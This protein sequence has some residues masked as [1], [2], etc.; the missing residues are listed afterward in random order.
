M[1]FSGITDWRRDLKTVIR[2]AGGR[3]RDM[4]FLCTESQIKEEA[5]LQDIDALL[6][7]GEVPNLFD[8]DE[9][10][11]VLEVQTWCIVC[12]YALFK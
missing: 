4:V 1:L 12:D 5:F 2:E 7:S 11:E 8:I 10:E 6:N 3:N 9:L